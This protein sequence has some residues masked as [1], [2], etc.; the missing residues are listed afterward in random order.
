MQSLTS[1][2][3]TNSLGQV[4]K[5]VDQLRARASALPGAGCQS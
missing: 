5:F 4:G 3:I 2:I 1:Q